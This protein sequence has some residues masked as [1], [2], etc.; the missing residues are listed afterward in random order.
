L[1]HRLDG[2][3]FTTI[4]TRPSDGAPDSVSPG[5]LIAL[6]SAARAHEVLR[7]D[8]TGRRPNTDT[9]PAPRRVEPH[10]LVTSQG[11]WYL[12]AWDLERDDWRIFRADRITP[13]S[14]NRSPFFAAGDPRR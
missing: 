10:H 11:R 4:P 12:V 7:I 8:Y 6:S 3:E 13:H 14:P 1:R 2:V 9:E 5:V